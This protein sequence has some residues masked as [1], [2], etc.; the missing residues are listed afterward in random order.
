MWSF[1]EP[2]LR[3]RLS[4]LRVDASTT[5]RVRSALLELIPSGR[6]S[7]V[8]VARHLAVSTRTL[9]RRLNDENASFSA[10]LN[11]VR[12]ELARHYLR[13]SQ[14]PYA[15]ISFLLGYGDPNSFYRAFNGWTGTTPDRVRSQLIQ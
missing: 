13:H 3:Q 5:E 8:Q 2:E 1:F 9:Q 6:T 11:S 15:Q 4:R 10:I 7:A 14:L 12:E